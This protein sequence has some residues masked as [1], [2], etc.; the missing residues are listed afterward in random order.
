MTLLFWLKPN[1][2]LNLIYPPAEAGGNSRILQLKQK[3][4][5]QSFKNFETT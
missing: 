4:I 1:L 5:N 2:H 3:D